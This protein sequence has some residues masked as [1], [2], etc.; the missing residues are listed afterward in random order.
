MNSIRSKPDSAASVRDVAARSARPSTPGT[1]PGPATGPCVNEKA[2]NER[3]C[4]PLPQQPTA[5]CRLGLF[6]RLEIGH[7]V[8]EVRGVA[9]P[10]ERHP[11]SLHLS[12]RVGDVVSQVGFI[13][14]EVCPL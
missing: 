7:D 2:W 1:R 13:P 5:G 8:V 9:Q 3:L 14:G 6:E 12:L 10:T 4:R 11:V